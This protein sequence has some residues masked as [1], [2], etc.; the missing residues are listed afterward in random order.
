MEGSGLLAKLKS[1]FAVAREKQ[2][3]AF[4]GDAIYTIGQLNDALE[5]PRPLDRHTWRRSAQELRLFARQYPQAEQAY[6]KVLNGAADNP[7]RERAL[8][9]QGWS[10]FKQGRLEQSLTEHR[11][12]IGKIDKAVQKGALHRRSGARKK[13]RAA[14]VRA[15]ASS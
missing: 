9:M 7:Y 5:P 2:S 4:A 8:Y 6:A 1:V 13:S 3:N 12:L 15:G 14:R 11:A 10:I